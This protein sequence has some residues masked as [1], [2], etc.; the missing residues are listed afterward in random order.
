MRHH[1]TPR[2]E[3]LNDPEA[4]NSALRRAG[5]EVT[6]S[7]EQAERVARFFVT[8]AQWSKTHN[9]S[10]PQALEQL[11]TDLIDAVAAQRCLALN[12]PLSDVGSG[13]GVPGLLVACLEPSLEV[14][15]V[16][17]LAERC[18]FMKTVAHQLKLT[19]VS[20]YRDRW[21]CAQV[22]ALGSTQVISRAV[23]SPEAWPLLAEGPQ[24][25]HI[26]QMLAHKRPEW[27][28]EG[29]ELS[30]EVAYEVPGGGARLV[31]RYS[32]RA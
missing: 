24:S 22:E 13:S 3:E 29:Y 10:G 17:P 26:L 30:A 20:V 25:A 2:L 12:A 18:A 27:P 5:L 28:L 31:R 7:A 9:L 21:P 4:M 11:S 23:V 1:P 15:L 16:E 32:R 8:R 14:R 6:L 19:G